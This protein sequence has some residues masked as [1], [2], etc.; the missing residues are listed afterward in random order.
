VSG[1]QISA[2]VFPTSFLWG[3]QTRASVDGQRTY[4]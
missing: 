4:V 1:N 2:N 3:S